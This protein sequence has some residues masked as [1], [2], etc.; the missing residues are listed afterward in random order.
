METQDSEVCFRPIYQE[1]G[2]HYK[3]V[4]GRIR[5]TTVCFQPGL[6]LPFLLPINLP[7]IF[8]SNCLVYKMSKHSDKC[9]TQF[10]EACP[11]NDFNN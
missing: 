6:Q 2:V 5:D 8:S 11:E 4:L 3:S 9:P 10:P 1:E 7:I